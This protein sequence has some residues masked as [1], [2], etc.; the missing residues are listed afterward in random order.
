MIADF[1]LKSLVAHV[2][3]R[4]V[5]EALIASGCVVLT[6]LLFGALFWNSAAG[7]LRAWEVLSAFNHCFL[8]LPLSLFLVWRRRGSIAGATPAPD[9]RAAFFM[10]VLSIVW[11]AASFAG[12]LEAQ[13]FV[14][15]TMVQTTLL[16]VLGAAYYRKLAAPFLYLYFLVP[17]G[18]YLIPILQAFTAKF[19]VLG[20]HLLGIP[21]FSNGAV[22]EVPSG[23]FAVAEACAG[24]RF[25]IA[26]VAFGVFFAIISYRSWRRRLAFVVLC[27][28]VP[29]IANGFR[30]LGLIAAAQ[31]IGNPAVAL[32]D[33]ILYGWIFFSIVLVILI[34]IGQRFS[35]RRE[36]D[37]EVSGVDGPPQGIRYPTVPSAFVAAACVVIAALAPAAESRLDTPHS[38]DLPGSA[39]GVSP[40]WRETVA[41]PEWAPRVGKPSRIFLQGFSDGRHHVERFVALYQP[42]YATNPFQ[43]N[44]R[45]ADEATWTFDSSRRALISVSGQE[46][47]VRVSVWLRGAKR[48]TIWSFYVID[49]GT[50]S[51]IWEAKWRQL[52][53]YLTGEKCLSA[54]VAISE[55][56]DYD[57]DSATSAASLLT[58]TE[59]L[60]SYLC[61]ST[62]R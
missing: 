62:K 28:V 44:N 40:P 43:L 8:V 55:E 60:G 34:L 48:R 45:D 42:G 30:V 31:W 59:P 6:L 29:V 51:D 19:A 33:H 38:L 49:G 5:R 17:T 20:L 21:V 37:A 13:Q 10:P 41:S 26:S 50:T 23:T 47:S 22:I 15:M 32:A 12:I 56:E 25:L 2:R 27:V 54:Y 16:G 3:D 1:H 4:G 35:D 24:L 58:A 53:A 18:L 9:L 46:I 14:V 36:G 52:Q 61:N 11:L 39:P 7:A 57:A